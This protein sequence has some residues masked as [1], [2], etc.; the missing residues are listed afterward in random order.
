M[1]VFNYLGYNYTAVQSFKII[2]RCLA[3]GLLNPR[4]AVANFLTSQ[5]TKAIIPNSTDNYKVNSVNTTSLIVYYIVDFVISTCNYLY[6]LIYN[7]YLIIIQHT[8]RTVMCNMV[9]L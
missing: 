4:A 2:H 6:I 8:D 9:T 5:T 3:L 1:A 7:T